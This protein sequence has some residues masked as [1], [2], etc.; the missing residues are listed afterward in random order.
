MP[1]LD[2]EYDLGVDIAATDFSHYF[3]RL[4][5]AMGFWVQSPEG[6]QG[7][8]DLNA[9]ITINKSTELQSNIN[10]NTARQQRAYPSLTSTIIYL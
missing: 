8:T 4:E 7:L 6:A 2:G 10:K 9:K 1:L 5:R 3:D